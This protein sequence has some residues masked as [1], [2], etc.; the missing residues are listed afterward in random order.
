[1]VG[2]SENKKVLIVGRGGRV[3]ICPD[4]FVGVGEISVTMVMSEECVAV[5]TTLVNNVG[6]VGV[7]VEV[8]AADVRYVE[9]SCVA[10]CVCFFLLCLFC[11]YY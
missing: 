2:L 11:G 9:L 3:D 10:R 7:N 5:D 8:G 1:M 6:V 4:C